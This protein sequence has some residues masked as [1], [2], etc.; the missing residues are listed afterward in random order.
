MWPPCHGG[1][2]SNG[3]DRGW[4]ISSRAGGGEE[5]KKN[6]AKGREMDGWNEG[7]SNDDGMSIR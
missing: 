5:K 2:W 7:A 1:G 6:K 3:V 4:A